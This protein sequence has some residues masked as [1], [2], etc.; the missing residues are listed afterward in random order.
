MVIFYG[1]LAFISGVATVYCIMVNGIMA[2]RE[3]MVNGILFTYGV[4]LLT[5][6]A[7]CGIMLQGIP[8][9]A[10][11]RSLPLPYFLGGTLGIATTYLFNLVVHELPAVQV[12]IIRFSGQMITSAVVDYLYFH[13]FS[14]GKV[15][16]VLLFLAGMLINAKA[17]R[18]P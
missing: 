7:L 8:S 3:G 15:L 9:Y 16:G 18:N 10:E 1:V 2:K 17:D 6:L 4:A 5:S 14:M 13:V 12:L 11:L